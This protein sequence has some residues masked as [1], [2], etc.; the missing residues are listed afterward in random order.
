MSLFGVKCWN[1]RLRSASALAVSSLQPQIKMRPLTH[2]G[3]LPSFWD[4]PLPLSDRGLKSVSAR[5]DLPLKLLDCHVLKKY[6]RL[7]IADVATPNHL[8]CFMKG[9]FDHLNILAFRVVSTAIGFPITR[10]IITFEKGQVLRDGPRTHVDVEQMGEGIDLKPCLLNQFGSHSEL[11]GSSGLEMMLERSVYVGGARLQ[12][13]E[14]AP[15]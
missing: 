6:D 11:G 1:L 13:L 4:R 12:H 10:P 5:Y 7:G 2:V 3:P 8:H 9:N 14:R 15:V